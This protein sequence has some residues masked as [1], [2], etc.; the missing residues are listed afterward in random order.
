MGLS[1]KLGL[2][3][4]M[5]SATG[6]TTGA[7]SINVGLSTSV[8]ADRYDRQ[9]VVSAAPLSPS[10]MI[11][12]S[13]VTTAAGNSPGKELPGSGFLV[14]GSRALTVPGSKGV[15]VIAF[16]QADIPVDVSVDITTVEDPFMVPKEDG[17]HI[18][19]RAGVVSFCRFTMVTGGEIDGMVLAKLNRSE[20]VPLK[21][22]KL[23]L[24]SVG[25]GA[26]LV[27]STQSEESG[28]Y[29]FKGVKPGNYLIS[30][31]E[32]EITRLKT[33]GAQPIAAAMPEGGDQISGK[34]FILKVVEK[35]KG[36]EAK[37]P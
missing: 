11:A 24:M 10:G 36:A 31:P 33:A 27:A 1:K 21:G 3:G 17:C 26:K 8:A 23:D 7:Y 37:G 35:Q 34:D 6:N 14:N 13:A 19:P 16:L 20:E 32:A 9:A 15:P 29:L 4:Y 25:V 30:I 22:V 12:V 28:Y 5:I 18:I 2:V